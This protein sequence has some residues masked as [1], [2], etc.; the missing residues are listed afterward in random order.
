M[1]KQK[2]FEE[3]GKLLGE[4]VDPIAVK[5]Y[6]EETVNE[7]HTLGYEEVVRF[8]TNSEGAA[9]ALTEALETQK[10]LREDQS[11]SNP[12]RLL[13][14]GSVIGSYQ[15]NRGSRSSSAGAHCVE[16]ALIHHER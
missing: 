4:G 16:D 5:T 10:K 11:P 12:N 13:V 6:L 9:I 14:E 15:Y 3:I 8:L 2:F 7:G 1:R